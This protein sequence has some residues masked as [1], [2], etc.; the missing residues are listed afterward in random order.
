MKLVSGQQL[1]VWRYEAKQGAI[2]ASVPPQEVDWLL[3]EVTEL[4]SLA[5]RLSSFEEC[6]QLQSDYSLPQLAQLWQQRLSARVPVQYLVGKSSWRNFRLEVSSDVLIPRPE[7]ECL[8]DLAVNAA[9]NSPEL[10]RGD[11]VDLGTGSG[12]IALGLAEVFPDATIHAVDFSAAA[13]RVAAANAN[14]LGFGQ[15]KFYQGFWWEPLTHLQG[16]V[17]GMISNPPYIPTTSVAKLQPEVAKHEPH[18]ALDGGE[19]GLDCIR[20]LVTTA[21]DYL[22][23]GGIF[24]IEMMIGQGEEVRDL[25]Q[26]QGSYQD[27]KIIPDLSGVERFALAYCV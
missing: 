16:K 8:I 9:G 17:K 20:Y 24:M 4:D 13:L 3:Q 22:H 18:L 15:I 7:T 10:R 2:A 6:S 14:R 5:L 11:W 25:L 27:I 19:D 21:P 23:S 12:A 26:Q 1:A